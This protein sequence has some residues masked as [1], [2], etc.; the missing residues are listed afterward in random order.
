VKVEYR[1]R[2]LKELSKISSPVR[3]EIEIFV[4]EDIL[5]YD[6]IFDSK[7]IEQLKNYPGFFK[8]RFVDYRVGIKKEGEAII[9][10]RALHR[11]EIY[12]YFP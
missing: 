5:K 2:F 4:F 8:I 12:R 3:K 11:K 10:E 1:K 6:S 7:K 9:L